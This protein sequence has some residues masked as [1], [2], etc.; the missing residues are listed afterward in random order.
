MD[1]R[2]PRPR[3]LG[4]RILCAAAAVLFLAGAARAPGLPL[5][6]AR[7]L[8]PG[9]LFEGLSRQPAE[10][11]V[12]PSDAGQRRSAAIGRIAFRAPL[13]LG[14][15]AARAGLS[16]ASC[17]RN[18]RGNPDFL[19]PG[20]SGAAGTADVTSSLMSAHRG[21]GTINPKPIPDLAGPPAKRIVSHDPRGRALE[22]FIHGLIVEEFDGPEP[23]PAVLDGLA[24]YVRSIKA[25]GC[26][27]S[28]VPVT[29]EGRLDEVET[30]LSLAR[31]ADAET[32]RLLIAAARSTL[33][34]VDE[35]FRVPGGA[36]SRD[37]LR[38]ADSELRDVRAGVGDIGRW[39]KRWP[40]RR[41]L[42]E[43]QAG[44]SLYAPAL[45]RRRIAP[46][47]S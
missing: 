31:E 27:G 13:L 24:A 46:G 8:S 21:D 7:W 14:G 18:G 34:A 17:H 37:A 40:E 30:A 16:C 26:R 12:M 11:L 39:L 45:L 25:E 29:L 20:L 28:S 15:Q 44:R 6:E 19:F 5:R 36:R 10:C 33:G 32:A 43:A 2:R 1:R 35:R 38:R 4:T 47:R 41:R 22:R 42:L 23:A 9:S 3:F